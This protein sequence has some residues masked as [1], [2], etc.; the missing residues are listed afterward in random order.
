MNS[1][2]KAAVLAGLALS[3][4]PFGADAQDDILR[5]S[6]PFPLT[7]IDPPSSAYLYYAFGAAELL[8]RFEPDGQVVPWVLQDL[9]NVDETT[10][11]LTLRQGV[12][13][14]NGERLT[15]DKLAR[16]LAYLLETSAVPRSY[17]PSS[18]RFAVT[19]ENEVTFTSDDP[20]PLLPGLLSDRFVFPVFDLDAYLEAGGPDASVADLMGLGLLT[21]PYAIESLDNQRMVLTRFEDHWLGTPPLAGINV[22]FMRD[23]NASMLAIQGGELDIAAFAPVALKPLTDATP[24]VHFRPG[25][26]GTFYRI[27]QATMNVHAEPFDEPAVRRA[28][29]SAIDYAEIAEEVFD[30]VYETATSF[31][32]PLHP[33]AVENQRTDIAAAEALLDEAGW[34]PGA[35]GMR[36]REGEPLRIDAY[37]DAGSTDLAPLSAAL[38]DQLRKVGIA[39]T[40]VPVE[41]PYGSA[42]VMD[43]DLA[44]IAQATSPVPETFIT[45]H[46]TS[47][48]DRN[49]ADYDNSEIAS[50]VEELSRTIDEA[51]RNAILARVQDIVIE[52]DPYIFSLVYF[53]P[54]AIVNDRYA[55]YQPGFDT[56]MIDATTA[57]SAE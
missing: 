39:F 38:Q 9:Q 22:E 18:A 5:I 4:L 29:M 46:M 15:A 41:D 54:P 47:A 23:A 43:W 57:P 21:A 7:Q 33:W 28:L 24:G 11:R 50:L 27:Y 13:F 52:E 19:G 10:W 6:T 31:Y 37:Y 48:G 26:G 34:L 30:G 8:M 40:A 25:E 53:Q 16:L 49:L 12:T 1:F 36:S 2:T 20:F 45:R 44:L 51:R 3:A 32:L 55:D 35:D 42:D 14:Q 17:F 56:R